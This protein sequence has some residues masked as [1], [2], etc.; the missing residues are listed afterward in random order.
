MIIRSFLPILTV[1]LFI[2]CKNDP[3]VVKSDETSQTEQE[4]FED[5]ESSEYKWGFIDRAGNL[6][7]EAI[8][9]DCRDFSEGL[10]LV[11]FEGRWGYINTK[12]ENVIPHAYSMATNFSS[13]IARVTDFD[14]KQF[15]IDKNGNEVLEITHDEVKDFK[16]GLAMARKGGLWGLITPSGEAVLPLNFEQIKMI[17][18][19][20]YRIKSGGKYGI[21]DRSGQILADPVFDKINIEGTAPYPSRK[22]GINGLIQK[23]FTWIES[24]FKK[25]YPFSGLDKTIAKDEKFQLINQK[26]EVISSLEFEEIRPLGEGKWKFKENGLWGI[27]N[28]EG[29]KITDPNFKLLNRFHDGMLVFGKDDEHWGYIDSLGKVVVPAEFPLN[30]DFHN[31][32]ARFITRRGIG[33][34]NK[35][36]EITI[37]PQFLE[38]KDFNEGLARVQVFR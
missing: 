34:I 27:L 18:P 8:Y 31:G 35:E 23:D 13:G 4:Y 36:G 2:S 20:L 19:K 7:I 11:N 15:L 21:I 5:Y 10:A 25:I 12:G 3:P 17:D 33:F 28:Q 14:K 32:L 29:E 22:D 24:S 9:D 30:W 16:D 37:K 38:V 1:L 26:A 6:T